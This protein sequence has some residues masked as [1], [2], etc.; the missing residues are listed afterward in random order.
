MNRPHKK[1]AVVTGASRGIGAAVATLLAEDGCHVVVNYLG[2][3]RQAVALC[4]SLARRGLSCAPFKADVSV[5]KE[6][7]ALIDF[8]LSTFKGADILVNNAGIAQ[9]KLF[10]DIT[11]AEWE[12]MFAVHV[13]AAFHCCQAALPYMLGR[14][15]GCIVNI[16]SIWGMTGAS[17]EVHY[18]AAK[19]AL[20]GFSKA[21]A[22]ELGPSGIRVNCVAP[23]AVDTDMNRGLSGEALQMLCDETPLGRLGTPLEI[24]QCVRFLC[25]DHGAFLTGQVIS[26]NG[27]LVV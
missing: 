10:T 20:I 13:N 24:A 2:S 3:E 8:A 27:G 25:S 4:D 16:A 14:K 22:K 26:P 18:S 17:C 12:G 9:Q 21:L 11:P 6:A 7:A 15:S 19:A 1:T 23:G 5:R